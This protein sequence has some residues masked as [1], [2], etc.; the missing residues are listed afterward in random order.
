MLEFLGEGLRKSLFSMCPVGV[1]EEP[2]RH[3][4]WS[5]AAAP[6]LADASTNRS[7]ASYAVPER[8]HS[9]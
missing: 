6:E 4:P 7:E 8:N 2:D 9:E 5:G 1:G 3:R